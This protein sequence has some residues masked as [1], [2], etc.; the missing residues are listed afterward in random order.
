MRERLSIVASVLTSAF[1]NPVLR[2]VGIAYALFSSS[3]FG[4]WIVLLVF[5]FDRGGISAELLIT[6]VQ[7]LPCVILAPAIGSV[8][9]RL[10]PARALVAS[11]A[12]QIV[13]IGGVALALAM[14][15]PTAL[16][17]ALAPLTA[18]S[19]C[20]TRPPQSAL[21]PSVVRT[22][23]ELTT[24]NVMTGWTEGAAA[25]VGPGL[26]GLLLALSGPTAAMAAMAAFNLVSML[27]A[28][29][30]SHSIGPI[31]MQADDE[32]K[33]DGLMGGVRGNLASTLL[34]PQIRV[35]LILTTFYFVLVGSLD[36]L[37]VV[38]ALGI[39]HMGPG[40][41]GYLNAAVGAGEL[42]AGFVTAFLIGRR[43][44]TRTLTTSLLA[45]VGALALVAV[46][47]RAGVALV[48]FVAVGL[49]G[50]VYNV[51]GKTLIQRAAPPDAIA[52]AFSVVESLMC[53][54]LSI[55]A[56]LVWAGY[57][58][59]GIR[60]ALVAPAI[61]AIVLIS[62]LWRRLRQVDDTANVPQVEIRLLG[63][64]RIFAP[65]PAPT[66]EVMARELER[67]SVAAGTCV[68]T[69]GEAGDRFYAVAAGV[70]DITRKGRHLSQ[71]GRGEGF[72]EIAL[73][74][75]VPRTATV[76]AVT[77]ALIYGLDGE[78]FIETVTAN[79]SVSRATRLVMNGH[80]EQ[81]HDTDDA[82]SGPP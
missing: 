76:T 56:V 41:A 80:L 19:I 42:L 65:L 25:L 52:G 20:M 67:I 71:I 77:N 44:L 39:L 8:A 4:V 47:P 54:G 35:L 64:L 69:E 62:V 43:R 78:L 12:T 22:A 82:G 61:A 1:G 66:L 72:G 50:A 10:D 63:S 11:Y 16:I 70:F 37:C 13:T 9:D 2:D 51:T 33:A 21:L 74:R 7:L 30:V 79:A 38:L 18:L 27:L 17:Y 5:A 6:L 75:D 3:E 55:G 59:A 31:T 29:R 24:A 14:N 40:G 15:A 46:F 49:S 73:I 36:F 34:K 60:I 68:V 45:W 81:Q 26:A 32:A 28:I 58:V 23:E 48:L 57:N 53:L